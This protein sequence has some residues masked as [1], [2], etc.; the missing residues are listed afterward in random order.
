MNNL[1]YIENLLSNTEIEWKPLG[2]LVSSSEE[3]DYKKKKKKDF[4][5]NGF[6][7]FIMVKSIQG[8]VDLLIKHL[9]LLL[10]N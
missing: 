9:L 5:D 4:V 10:K 8:M 6:L 7:Q 2:K 1:S 3:T